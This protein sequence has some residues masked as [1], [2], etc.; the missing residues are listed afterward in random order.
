MCPWIR[1]LL[2]R[3]AH[4]STRNSVVSKWSVKINRLKSS[5]WLRQQVYSSMVSNT[6]EGS[7]VEGQ[8]YHHKD[9]WY[10]I[11]GLWI[12]F[13]LV[14]SSIIKYYI[15]SLLYMQ[16]VCL[17]FRSTRLHYAHIFFQNCIVML[18]Y[19]LPQLLVFLVLT[20]LSSQSSVILLSVLRLFSSHSSVS[21][22]C[23]QK[24]INLSP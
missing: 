4:F 5:T 8:E 9:I 22:H 14:C 6:G 7:D 23:A 15:L 13:F 11:Y 21:P 18:F 12:R 1:E 17:P 20:S 3:D 2:R 16:N 24:L 10:Q 19:S